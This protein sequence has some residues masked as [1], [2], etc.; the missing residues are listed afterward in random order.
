MAKK[1]KNT[2]PSPLPD[3]T[4]SASSQ[5]PSK[6]Y[7]SSALVP[8]DP[9]LHAYLR[10]IQKYPLLSREEERALAL[11]Y[12]QTK[13]RDAL[14]KLVTSNLRFVVKIAY[15]YV[16]YRIRL[17]DLI[18]E[19][20]AGLLKATKD[21]NPYKEVRLLTYAVW[22]IRSYIQDAVLKNHSLVKIGT[23]QAQKRLFYRMR[24]EQKKLEQEYPLASHSEQI[25]LL[26]NNLDVSEKEVINMESRLSHYD[27]S[28]STPVIDGTAKDHMQTLEALSPMPD[29][30]LIEHERKTLFKTLLTQFANTLEERDKIIFHKRLISEEPMTLQEIGDEYGIT[31]ERAR[32]LEEQLK[33]KLKDFMATHYPDFALLTTQGD[34][35]HD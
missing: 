13:D 7:S 10:E 21:F 16:N 30:T 25:K 28:L 33:E 3:I 4:P 26:A 35:T 2:L 9:L 34:D 24:L 22:W 5:K 29:T 15:E 20:N 17:L 6:R 1:T 12:Y 23:T 32:Q 8:S 11:Q 18:Q 31:K 27:F 14:Q 19:G